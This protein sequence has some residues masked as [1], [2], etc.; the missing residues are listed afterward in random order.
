M[1]INKNT[2]KELL[3]DLESDRIERTVSTDNTDKFSE[4][5]CAFANDSPNHKQAGYLLIGVKDDG[6]LSGLK[7][8]DEL[9]KDIASIR[10]NGQILPQPAMIVEKYSFQDGD[11][12]IVQVLPSLNPPVRYRGRVWIRVGPTKQLASPDD[13]KRLTEK[14][15]ATAKT[16]DALPCQGATIEDL[17]VKI[18]KENYLLDAVAPEIV[19]ENNRK[20]DEQL[21]SLKMYDLLHNTPT[22]AGVLTLGF[23]SLDFMPGAYIQYVKFNGKSTDSI[24]NE[25]RFSGNLVE[26]LK[27]LDDFIK[28]NVITQKPVFISALREKPVFNYPYIAIREMLMNAIMHRSYESNAPIRFYEYSDRIEIQ[29]PGALYGQA[30][31]TNFPRVSDYRNPVIAEVLKNLGYINRFNVG[32][33]NA[34]ILLKENGNLEPVFDLE[35]EPNFLVTIFST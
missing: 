11:V 31:K 27:N 14:R 26:L 18:F 19:K 16:F 5:I 32:I 3:T 7:V 15:T 17:N 13:E 35:I 20:P 21:G 6:T 28:N 1:S 34:K 10:N 25:K 24:V 22:N 2:I 4:A 12:A 30:N 8:T 23:D 9:L 29:N 33:S